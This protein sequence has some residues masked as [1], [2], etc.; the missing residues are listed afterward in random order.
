MAHVGFSAFEISMLD[1]QCLRRYLALW[2]PSQSELKQIRKACL[3]CRLGWET[4]W[5][6]RNGV[7]EYNLQVESMRS[8]HHDWKID[9]DLSQ[10]IS[11][12]PDSMLVNR[13]MTPMNQTISKCVRN[14]RIKANRALRPGKAMWRLF[15]RSPYW[16]G[17]ARFGTGW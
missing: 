13:S 4:M 15:C 3:V 5:L 6:P 10:S 1:K 8:S 16:F 14:V 2:C 17:C 7:P 9:W 12:W 11:K